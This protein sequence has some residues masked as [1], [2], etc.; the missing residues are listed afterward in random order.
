MLKTV[1]L[2][3]NSRSKLLYS[4]IYSFLPGTCSDQ[5]LKLKFPNIPNA[6]YLMNLDVAFHRLKKISPMDS[7]V[8]EQQMPIRSVV[9]VVLLFDSTCKL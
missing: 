8:I 1:I 6:G 9:L 3:F 5:A 2:D 7:I 4:L